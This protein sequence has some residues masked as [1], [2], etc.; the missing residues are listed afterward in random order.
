MGIRKGF[1]EKE[2]FGKDIE[3]WG[4]GLDPRAWNLILSKSFILTFYH[5][6]RCDHCLSSPPDCKHSEGRDLFCSLLF[7]HHLDQCLTN[8]RDSII[9]CGANDRVR[10]KC[11]GNT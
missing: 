8:R 4:E 6:F 9:P 10:V 5:I 7:P 2:L 3:E 11:F 1:A